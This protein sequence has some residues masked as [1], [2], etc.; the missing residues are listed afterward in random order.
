MHV[1]LIG[2]IGPAATWLYYRGLVEAFQD[3][4]DPMDLTIVH[5]EASDLVRNFTEGNADA[6]A[7]IFATLIGR[8][9]DAGAEMAAVTSLGGH[10]C[11]EELKAIS[12]LPLID[13]IPEIGREIAEREIKRV[14]LL[15]TRR[16]MSTGIYG[17][18][19]SV[20]W[21][22]PQ[23]DE[24][25]AVHATYVAMAV[26]GVVTEAQ[27][28]HLFEAGRALCDEQGADAVLLSGTDLFLAFEDH[29]PG[30]P[31]IDSADIHIAAIA[32]HLAA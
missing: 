18:L 7:A 30:Y 24:L 1:G 16:V 6:Q 28:A 27:R 22:A 9:K 10:F 29:D 26:P 2:G 20:D 19:T 23:G 17:G 32:R 3:S 8:M 25:E 5:A 15:G 13:A 31:V 11:I 14:G 4:G 21:V 12:P